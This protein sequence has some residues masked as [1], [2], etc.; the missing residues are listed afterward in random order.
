MIGLHILRFSRACDALDD[1]L[2]RATE[3]LDCRRE[4]LLYGFRRGVYHD[5]RV[6]PS[7]AKIFV[8]PQVYHTL[9]EIVHFD[10]LR[11]HH[12]IVDDT[13]LEAVRCIVRRIS[14]CHGVWEKIDKHRFNTVKVESTSSS[15]RSRSAPLLCGAKDSIR[16]SFASLDLQADGSAALQDRFPKEETA[17]S[18]MKQGW[19]TI[20]RLVLPCDSGSRC[21][22]RFKE[23]ALSGFQE[24]EEKLSVFRR[25]DMEWG[26]EASHQIYLYTYQKWTYEFLDMLSQS[27]L[28]KTCRQELELSGHHHVLHDAN[29]FVHSNQWGNILQNIDGLTLKRHH[30]IVTEDLDHLV[31]ATVDKVRPKS[32]PKV[33]ECTVLYDP[34]S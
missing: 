9:P 34:F 29:V 17:F 8:S 18:P 22:L 15:N 21:H 5:P 32:R 19:M 26:K 30:V 13:F 10:S 14:R 25:I 24:E 16:R 31:H 12:V 4:L 28:L 3:L 7:G 23:E 33:K 27:P 1:E 6:H 2:L 11:S 20:P